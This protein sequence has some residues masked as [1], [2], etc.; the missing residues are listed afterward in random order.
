MT[1]L[2]YPPV[3][4]DPEGARV[5]RHGWSLPQ[6]WAGRRGS[7]FSLRGGLFSRNLELDRLCGTTERLETAGRAAFS[8][9][10]PHEQLT[11][12]SLLPCKKE[13]WIGGS[14][15]HPFAFPAGSRLPMMWGCGRSVTAASLV[16]VCCSE[17]SLGCGFKAWTS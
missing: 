11:G 13:V 16:G 8:S 9:H 17:I 15:E 1:S 4:C 6:F 5:T 14:L 7:C 10:W 12:T 2:V 3:R